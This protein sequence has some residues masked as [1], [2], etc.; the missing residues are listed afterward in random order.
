MAKMLS[1]RKLSRPQISNL[2]D[3][4]EFAFLTMIDF[5]GGIRI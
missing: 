2:K 3:S 5:A 1:A 4:A